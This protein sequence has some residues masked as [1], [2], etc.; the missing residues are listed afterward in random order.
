MAVKSSS[1]SMSNLM[2]MGFAMKQKEKEKQEKPAEKS[3]E[4]RARETEVLSAARAKG[5]AGV[6]IETAVNK[7][8]AIRQ[9]KLDELVKGIS[10]FEQKINE[11]PVGSGLHGRIMGLIKLG[12][13]KLQTD[14]K[15][16]AYVTSVSGMRAQIARGLGDVGN[17][18]EYEQ[19]VAIDLL[20]KLTDNEETRQQKMLNFRDYVK[21]KTGVTTVIPLSNKLKPVIETIREFNTEADVEKAKLPKGTKIKIAGKL[22]IWE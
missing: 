9:R 6:G 10:F 8:S 3:L 15:A 19:Q 21:A 7:E 18:S 16:A 13:A 4:E 22:A 20:P 14:P 2:R 1:S 11:I 12:E 17:L 5:A